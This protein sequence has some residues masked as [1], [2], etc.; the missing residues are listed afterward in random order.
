MKLKSVN[1]SLALGLASLLATALTGQS[2][3]PLTSGHADVGIDYDEV[4]N[5]WNLHIHDEENNVEYS[6]PTNAILV[7]KGDAHST[8]QTGQEFIGSLGSDVWTLPKVEDPNLLFLGI[9]S[10]EIV[11]GT[12]AGDVFSLALTGFSGPGNL[13]IYDLDAF[14]VP[15][16]LFS[17]VGGSVVA[18]SHSFP[19]GN[20]S[21]LN[22][23]FTAIG[24]YTLTF[25]ASANSTLN[26][27]TSSGPVNYTFQVQ[28]VP[29][30]GTL[31]LAGIG[32]VAA[33]LA[34][35]KRK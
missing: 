9:G 23:A 12:F 7:V 13:F 1:K 27:L 32:G 30:P 22:W 3:T 16:V 17:A 19:S 5:E 15:S 10:E 31:A 34:Y 4:L 25:E 21:H 28:P 8:V 35:R 2:Q 11:S 6:P 14:D 24:D 29:E 18:S 33:L 20:H 26:G